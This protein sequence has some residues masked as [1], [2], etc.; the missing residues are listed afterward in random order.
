MRIVVLGSFI[1]WT[2]VIMSCVNNANAC[3]MDNAVFPETVETP[4]VE[5]KL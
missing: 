4:T 2:V 5:F 3:D 1:F